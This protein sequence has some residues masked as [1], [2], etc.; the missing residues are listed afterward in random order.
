M[1]QLLFGKEII[2]SMGAGAEKHNVLNRVSM[3]VGAGE[4]ISVMGP[5][6]SGKSTLLYALSGMDPV[7][8]GEVIFE[9]QKLSGL[10]D[11]ALSDLR[12]NRMGFVFQQPTLLKNLSIL[13]NIIL[14]QMRDHR[15]DVK[16]LTKKAVMLMN[17]M[18]IEELKDRGI[19]QASGGQLQ[20]AGICRALMGGPGII[21]ADEPTGALNTKAA[22]EIMELFTRINQEGTAI[23][24]VTHDPVIAARTERVLFLCDGEIADE[25]SLSK[26]TGINLEERT[27][28]VTRRMQAMGI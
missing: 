3:E 24:L 19:T 6:G 22:K 27:R 28:E 2:K 21:F 13:D 1:N 16:R 11:D 5:S 8:G 14:P 12:R 23:L 17:R 9:N 26:Y 20:R 25:C 10:S 18:G 15:R 7:D 4:F